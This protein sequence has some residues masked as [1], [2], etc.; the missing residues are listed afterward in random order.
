MM[1][2]VNTLYNAL[3][4]N[5]DFAKCDFKLKLALGGGMKTLDSV[6]DAFKKV[7]GVPVRDGYGLTETSPILTLNILGDTY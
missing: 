4:N 1:T 5:K 3:A 2:G 7:T 6:S